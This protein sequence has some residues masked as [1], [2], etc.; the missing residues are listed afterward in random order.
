MEVFAGIKG[1]FINKINK[2]YI[3]T[4][5]DKANISFD[6]EK[7]KISAL[8][9]DTKLFILKSKKRDSFLP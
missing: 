8:L 5:S 7:L 6:T 2:S 3:A 1:T 4:L 9:E